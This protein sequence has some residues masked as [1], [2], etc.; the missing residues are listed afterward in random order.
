MTNQ[1]ADGVNKILYGDPGHMVEQPDGTMKP[2][3]GYMQ[4]EGADMMNAYP[5]VGKKI[6]A[7]RTQLAG[8]LQTP[9]SQLQFDQYSR[10]LSQ[11]KQSE[12]GEKYGA[13]FK[14]WSVKTN[15]DTAGQQIGDIVR[16]ADKTDNND[17][18]F[19]GYRENMRAAYVK[20]AHI[21]GTG[22]EGTATAVRT[23]DH[24]AWHARLGA[25]SVDKPD[26]ALKYLGEP[27]VKQALGKDWAPLQEMATRRQTEI[28][29]LNLH[30]EAGQAVKN[31]WRGA[32][33]PGQVSP[34]S[35][36]SGGGAA[37]GNN[38]GNII[39]GPWARLQPGY[40]GANGRFARFDTVESGAAAMGKNL[41]GYAR[42]G[43]S[44][45]NQ[46][47]AKWAP[48]GDGAN[49][50][51]AYAKT[52]SAA[53]GIDPDSPVNLADLG[54]QA[55]II[56][57]MARVEQ[58]HAVAGLSGGVTTGHSADRLPVQPPVTGGEPPPSASTP[59]SPAQPGAT[60][61]AF[62]PPD[63]PGA[64]PV[65]PQPQEL[66]PEQVRA[67]HIQY[68]EQS[69]KTEAEKKVAEGWTNEAYRSAV[70]AA[71]ASEKDKTEKAND[72]A[73]D[74]G[75]QVL[76]G[77]VGPDVYQK[78]AQDPRLQG[79]G[80]AMERV[81]EFVNKWSGVELPSHY[82][83]GFVQARAD[84]LS[85]PGS[86]GHISDF[87]EVYKR[88][89]DPDN[90]ITPAGVNNL[91][92]MHQRNQKSVSLDWAAKG[93]QNQLESAKKYL[94]F[95]GE[96]A[97]PGFEGL[98]DPDGI[99]AYADFTVRFLREYDHLRNDAQETH[100]PKKLDAFLQDKNVKEMANSIRSERKIKEDK[101][102]ASG[103][104]VTPYPLPEG[105]KAADWSTMVEN[106]PTHADGSRINPDAWAKTLEVFGHNPTD[107]MA[108]QFDEDQKRRSDAGQPTL[109]ISGQE[110]LR[111][112][113]GELKPSGSAK[114]VPAAPMP[115]YTGP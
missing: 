30:N 103:A 76:L 31:G 84:M 53:T 112:L 88:S 41:S 115:I 66:T 26:M 40:A 82:G 54:V 36:S 79:N 75:K 8:T 101:L 49:D 71:Q 32:G 91:Y 62:T 109:A 59:Q 60:P 44:T 37:H 25:L 2:E 90:P 64:P 33:I 6:E 58:G 106:A 3:T 77:Q 5:E 104:P 13:A 100:D 11:I 24:D 17:A 114:A 113:R 9:E 105:I 108:K 57:A 73:S 98:K 34:A 42:E 69:D 14:Q 83:K 52:I 45:L 107:D 12:I 27:D 20:N 1:F 46:L 10:R 78:I 63:I 72:A 15:G 94:T 111:G 92:E 19:N 7:L 81:A 35:V 38:P 110:I 55:K 99:H 67:L 65:P 87:Q 102:A 22:A 21:A 23:A 70:I 61:A 43:I 93:A 48:K 85:E 95:D 74:Y 80:P 68:I 18:A 47:T 28:G 16:D 89:L 97:F 96:G 51:V 56:P 39:D 86:P 29:G 50:P 4:L